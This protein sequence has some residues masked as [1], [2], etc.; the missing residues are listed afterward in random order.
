LGNV[1]AGGAFGVQVLFLNTHFLE[2]NF[3]FVE[4]VARAF[5][6]VLHK[7]EVGHVYNIGGTNEKTVLQVGM[8]MKPRRLLT[9]GMQVA[10]DLIRLMGYENRK[11]ELMTFVEDRA[12]NDFRQENV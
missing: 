10:H 3:L 4:D 11:D 12:F 6:T 2:R 9:S 8:L 5:D 7:A 1:G